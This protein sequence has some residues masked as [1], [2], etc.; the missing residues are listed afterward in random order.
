MTR[1]ETWH[2]TILFLG[3]Q[4]REV[5]PRIGQATSQVAAT[6]RRFPLSA[7]ELGAPGPLD[8]PRL[9][10]LRCDDSGVLAGAQQQLL[11]Q[12][13]DLRPETA[14]FRAHI[15]LGRARKP[16]R[17]A[18]RE[19]LSQLNQI[20]R[21]FPVIVDRLILYRSHLERSG[22]RYAALLDCDLECGE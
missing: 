15:T 12:L 20:E 9:V 5:L 3:S 2:L 10:W 8:R 18:F 1:P 19:T 16:S 7:G 13:G 22:A 14:A 4:P 11:S 17:V 6:T 21:P